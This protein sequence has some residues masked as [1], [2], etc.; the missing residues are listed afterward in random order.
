[1]LVLRSGVL[2]SCPTV[3]G[4][5]KS[6]GLRM[7]VTIIDR[8]SDLG[9]SWE[10]YMANLMSRVPALE[11]QGARRA[12]GLLILRKNRAVQAIRAFWRWVVARPDCVRIPD[13]IFPPKI[14]NRAPI[15][16]VFIERWTHDERSQIGMSVA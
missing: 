15:V 4:A 5:E 13:R 16:G 3:L 8:S 1:M 10:H 12:S 9:E 11:L 14:R 6:L 2:C 7:V